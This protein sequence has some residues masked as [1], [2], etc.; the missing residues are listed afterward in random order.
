MKKY[1]PYSDLKIF[2]HVE[3]IKGMLEGKRVSPIYLRIK[4]TN[5]C[6]QRCYFCAY[7]D[8]KLF[9]DRKV[10]R[11]SIPVE[12]L[13]NTLREFKAMGGKAVTY[14]GG[15]EP[16]CYHSIEHILE[17]TYNLDLDCS[18]ITNGQALRG[19]VVDFLKHAKWIRVSFDASNE[20]VY[21]DIRQVNTYSQVVQNIEDFAKI[22]DKDCVLGVNCVI[23]ETNANQIYD[24][25]K[26]V[27]TIGCNN[28]K[29]S[30]VLV[31]GNEEEYHNRIKE[32]VIEQIDRAKGELED[33]NFRIVDKYSNDYALS[34][35]YVKPYH[36][37]YIQEYFAVV[38]ADSKVYRCHQRAYTEA[39][40]I[41]DLTKHTFKEIWESQET[42]DKIRLFDPCE[43]CNFRCA[44]DE[45]N[46]LLNDFFN[47]DKNHIN[48]V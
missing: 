5:V 35:S 2:R 9:G 17:L 20:N 21:H 40:L 24:V 11:D 45:R 47:I 36:K 10:Q 46:S 27:K 16:L 41:G 15:G 19:N 3:H 38:A 4:P 31:K 43:E 34:D 30:P 23:S 37:C 29:L 14:S 33:D 26:L 6:N 8:D 12:I 13:E 28:I 48:F 1:L 25:C 44:F 42:I 39:G 22:K 18:M 32:G 7:D